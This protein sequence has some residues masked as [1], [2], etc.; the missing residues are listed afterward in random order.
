MSVWYHGVSVS[1]KKIIKYE[2]SKYLMI[3][4][5]LLQSTNIPFEYFQEHHFIKDRTVKLRVIYY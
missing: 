5:H 4:R 1:V 3:T 2:P